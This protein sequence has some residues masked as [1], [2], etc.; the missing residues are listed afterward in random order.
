MNSVK[1]AHQISRRKTIKGFALL[2]MGMSVG[3]QP[4][5]VALGIY[6]KE[7]K[8][9]SSKAD[10][11]LGTFMKTVVPGVPV[12]PELTQVFHDKF[13]KME[14]YHGFLASD[15]CRRSSRIYNTSFERLTTQ[16]RTVVIQDGLDSGGVSVNFTLLQSI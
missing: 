8:N 3:C 6:P 11:V 15:L 10:Q 12:G 5:R 7:F 9:S 16:Q 1:N 4:G 14:K 13:Y 2:I